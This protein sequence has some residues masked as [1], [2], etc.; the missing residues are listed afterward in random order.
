MFQWTENSESGSTKKLGGGETTKT[1][2][3]YTRAW[4]DQPVDASKFHER[5]G[6]ANPQMTYRSRST[7]AP[8]PKLGA[9]AVPA[10]LL[11]NFG[12]EEPLAVGDQQAQAVPT[13]LNKPVQLTDA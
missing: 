3:K 1:T 7:L 5:Q 6:H 12:P 2:Y 10:D 8:Q 9:F 4:S 13:R 11:R